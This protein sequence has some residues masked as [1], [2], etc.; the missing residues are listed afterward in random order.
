MAVELD[1]REFLAGAGSLFLLSLSPS[2]VARASE[3]DAVLA[4]A[5]MDQ[6]GRHGIAILD[7]SGNI[8]A[9]HQLPARGHGIVPGGVGGRAVVFARRPGNFAMAF[10]P[11]RQS[12]PELFHSPVGRHFYGHGAFSSD[13]KLLFAT[14]NDFDQGAGVV[15]VYDATGGF[16]R[17]GEFSSGGIGPHEMIFL[18]DNDVLC[19]ANGGIQTHPDLGRTKL[20]LDSMES[21]VAFIDS[22]NGDLLER[23][24]VPSTIQRL[25][26]RH[27]AVDSRSAV[28]FGGQYQGAREDQPPLVA[29][30]KMGEGLEF[31]QMEP[32]VVRKLSN[33]VG[34]VASFNDGKKIVFSSPVGGSL[35]V[36]DSALRKAVHWQD[37]EQACGVAGVSH[38]FAYST[39]GGEFLKKDL[40]LRWDN[41]LASLSV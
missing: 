21:S 14:E 28:W 29:C 36:I 32:E 6:E 13:G 1:R 20:N 11:L 3:G 2:Q 8:L 26:L 4:S 41:H 31:L 35:V 25:S 9:K 30:A 19:I 39:H 40:P 33:Y 34:S 23:H 16:K 18:P 12:V 5:F 38:G 22:R 15:G 27:M 10:D 7:E 24:V 17:I 37:A